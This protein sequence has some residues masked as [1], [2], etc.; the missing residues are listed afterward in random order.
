MVG[1]KST[2]TRVVGIIIDTMYPYTFYF[3]EAL[4]LEIS[5][6]G[7]GQIQDLQVREMPKVSNCVQSTH[8]IKCLDTPTLMK[9]C[10]H[11]CYERDKQPEKSMELDFFTLQTDF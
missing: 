2:R 4:L 9:P 11:N 3:I 6:V 8:E 7:Q 1:S 10:P 5:D